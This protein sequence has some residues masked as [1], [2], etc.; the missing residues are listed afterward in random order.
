MLKTH[1]LCILWI[2]I[3]L[4]AIA[5]QAGPVD[6][7]EIKKGR[8]CKTFCDRCGCIGFY[9]GEECICE[10]NQE[11]NGGDTECIAA[12][13]ENAK[14]NNTPY[15]ILIQGPSSNRFLKNALLFDQNQQTCPS[16]S[17]YGRT[18]RSTVVIYK[19]ITDESNVEGFCEKPLTI[20]DEA[21]LKQN[22]RGKRAVG[23]SWFT[24]FTNTLVKPAPIPGMSVDA[25]SIEDLHEE[26][27]EEEEQT[28]ATDES[29]SEESIIPKIRE[30]RKEFRSALNIGENDSIVKGIRKTFTKIGDKA[31]KAVELDGTVKKI[32][33]AISNL[34]PTTEENE[35]T[36]TSRKF[37]N[38]IRGKIF[39]PF[40]ED[41]ELES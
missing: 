26:P 22:F 32:R 6:E 39:Q 29:S 41:E 37:L 30:I 31:L 27:E 38:K 13:Q 15:E 28:T 33:G 36:S 1:H 40:G 35:Q 21:E 9:C 12:I 17:E 16:P 3:G 24:D 2:T 4:M 14:E 10:C 7:N 8:D 18:K 5:I 25:E 34:L 19:P 20:E 11:K 23:D